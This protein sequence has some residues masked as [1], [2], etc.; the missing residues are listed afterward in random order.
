MPQDLLSSITDQFAEPP[1]RKQLPLYD[2]ILKGTGF[3]YPKIGVSYIEDGSEAEYNP[4]SN[5]ISG[6]HVYI[7]DV[8]AHEITHGLQTQG[9]TSSAP[10]RHSRNSYEYGGPENLTKI[11]QESGPDIS[12]FPKEAQADI[13]GGW[14]SRQQ[15]PWKPRQVDG[16]QERGDRVPLT[17]DQMQIYAPFVQALKTQAIQNTTPEELDKPSYGQVV[18]QLWRGLVGKR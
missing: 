6:P 11:Y 14:A 2:R 15:W 1:T 13:V 9:R 17:Q 10:F 18:G 8:L 7:P 16:A 12:R 5:V 4:R 3:Q